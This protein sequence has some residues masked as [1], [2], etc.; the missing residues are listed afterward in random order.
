[1][2]EPGSP[3][4]AAGALPV[5]PT[6]GRTTTANLPVTWAVGVLL[7]V[8]AIVNAAFAAQFPSA[9]PVESLYAFGVTIDLAVAG[10]FLVIRAIVVR[11][12]VPAPPKPGLGWWAPV[13]LAGSLIVLAAYL[14]LG[15]IDWLIGPPPGGYLRR[16]MA[17][18]VGPFLAG[19]PW[20]I[21][22]VFGVLGLR[23]GRSALNAAL[24]ILAIVIGLAVAVFVIVATVAYGLG[25]TA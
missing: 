20:V 17:A 23:A 8:A 11:G 6:A 5:V 7:L 13:A 22:L 12:R 16:Y 3:Y 18:S 4:A 25:Y 21:G 15:G 10:A 1:M 14:F 2:T 9:A 24:C 19:G